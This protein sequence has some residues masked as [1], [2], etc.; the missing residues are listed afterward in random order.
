MTKLLELPTELVI[1]IFA[2]LP[3]RTLIS[4]LSASKATNELISTSTLLQYLIWLG[5][6]SYSSYP[7]SVSLLDTLK[8]LKRLEIGW[9]EWRV[10][11]LTHLK[12]THQPSGIYDLTC[13][14]FLLGESG[15]GRNTN[16]LRWVDL[17][18]GGDLQWYRLD[19]QTKIVDLALNVHEWDLIAVVT[20][21]SFTF[22]KFLS[23]FLINL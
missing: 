7:T 17:R 1:Y 5:S 3:F 14:V 22:G 4:L 19:L 21:L 23:L 12:V 11:S 9:S 10:Q 18:Q 2:L 6:S 13:G 20:S 15:W 8:E 16:A